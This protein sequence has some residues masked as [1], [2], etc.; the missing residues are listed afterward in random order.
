M[1]ARL[2]FVNGISRNYCV[3]VVAGNEDF[4]MPVHKYEIRAE[5]IDCMIVLRTFFGN[6]RWIAVSL[7]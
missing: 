3:Y 7:H 4:V 2:V 1:V 5:V 6:D